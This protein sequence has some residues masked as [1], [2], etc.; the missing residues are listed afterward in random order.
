VNPQ[1]LA[2]RSVAL[3]RVH[4]A[5][6]G[7][8]LAAP[9]PAPY[10]NAWLRDGAFVADALSQVGERERAAAFFSWCASVIEA[11]AERMAAREIVDGR[12]TVDGDEVPDAWSGAQL[13]G[14]GAWVWALG[15]H[16]QR[17]G[18]GLSPWRTAA[19]LSLRYAADCWMLPCFDWWE[20]RRGVHVPTLAALYAGLTAGVVE[21]PWAEEAADGIRAAVLREGVV[22]G[23]L[24]AHLCEG[25]LDASLLAVA[26]P[27]DLMDPGDPVMAATRAAIEAELVVGGGVHRHAED[28][29]YGGGL[30]ILLAA[31]LGSHYVREGRIGEARAQLEWVLGTATAEGELPEQVDQHLL[32]P[33]RRA[34]WVE[35]W[36]PPARPLLW[37][38]AMFLTLALDLG[39]LSLENAA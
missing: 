6:S 16:L 7:A 39:V 28:E 23:R 33:E 2:A 20:E 21:E 24:S 37:S 35:R 22:D 1:A 31:L 9:F 15:R 36:G 32:C 34:E 13:D 11:R 19:E 17:H 14:Y 29:F 38:H 30:W 26:T 18:A 12:F 8:F 3:I 4:Q 5:P 27:F 10:R 25:G